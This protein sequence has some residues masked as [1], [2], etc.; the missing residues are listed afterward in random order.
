MTSG[1]VLAA[2]D[3]GL[4]APLMAFLLVVIVSFLLCLV[5]GV[6]ND[7]VADFFTANRP[8]P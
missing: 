6:D 3:S 1:A 2:G 7:T 8:C 5:A 4:F